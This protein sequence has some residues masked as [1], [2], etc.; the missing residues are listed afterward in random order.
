MFLFG[1]KKGT[2]DWAELDEI[3]LNL[4]PRDLEQVISF[5]Q[6]A[7]GAFAQLPADEEEHWHYR[8]DSELWS[9]GQPD[10]ILVIEPNSGADRK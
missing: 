8:D 3:V 2:E 5:L 7:R 6:N 4:D 1:R 10:L 9:E